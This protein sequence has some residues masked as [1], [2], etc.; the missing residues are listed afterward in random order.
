MLN[1]LMY[2][3]DGGVRCLSLLADELD[4]E[5][6]MQVLL[7]ASPCVCCINKTR[8]IQHFSI[9][10]SAIQAYQHSQVASK[11]HFILCTL[12][13]SQDPALYSSY[14]GGSAWHSM[15]LVLTKHAGCPSPA[16]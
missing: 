8:T 7:K 1:A 10:D 5:Q 6:V 16:S 2:A 11:V 14:S 12:S 3:V 15:A 4:E 13:Y 9:V